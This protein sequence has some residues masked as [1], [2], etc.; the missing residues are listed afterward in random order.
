MLMPSRSL[1]AVPIER[2][3]PRSCSNAVLLEQ[4]SLSFHCI[5][6]A[7]LLVPLL[8]Q[9]RVSSGRKLRRMDKGESDLAT[10]ENGTEF[11][12]TGAFEITDPSGNVLRTLYVAPSQE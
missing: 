9:A 7:R 11:T 2:I 4:K 12:A 6:H 3:Q 8:P 1:I 10:R 5:A